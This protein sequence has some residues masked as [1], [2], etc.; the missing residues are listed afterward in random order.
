VQPP[1]SAVT[2]FHLEIPEERLADLR[3]R[4]A[5]TRWPEAETVDDWSQGI[6]LTYLRAL[7]EYWAD[8]YDLRSARR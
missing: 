7:C 8:G 2:P 1:V 3:T 6:P 5:G 4:L